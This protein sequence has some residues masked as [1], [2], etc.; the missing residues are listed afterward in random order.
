MTSTPQGCW[1]ARGRAGYEGNQGEQPPGD[2][3]E[4]LRKKLLVL[5][6][7]G[8]TIKQNKAKGW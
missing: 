2:E 4:P 1:I 8:K 6:A 5:F 3:T 7:R